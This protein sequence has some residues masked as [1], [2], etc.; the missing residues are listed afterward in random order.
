MGLWTEA[1]HNLS[2]EVFWGKVFCF[3][4]E[5]SVIG[6]VSAGI[7]ILNC[8]VP[9]PVAL[10]FINETLQIEQ[11]S[12]AMNAFIAELIGLMHR[13]GIYTILVKGQG[14]AQC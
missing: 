13:A 8:K 9:K 1:S 2:E 4:E 5:Q 3:A 12:K 7:E 14:V 6:L 11:R 10:Q